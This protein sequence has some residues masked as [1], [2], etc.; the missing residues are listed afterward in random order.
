MATP[1]IGFDEASVEWA[2]RRIGVEGT[3]FKRLTFELSRELSDDFGEPP[4]GGGET[5]WK[6]AYVKA[7]VSRA[8]IVGA[9]RFKQPFGREA[10]TGETN[11]DFVYRSL[12]SR[13][14]TPGRDVGVM[15]EGRLLGR[16]IEYQ[17]GYFTRDGENARTSE[18]LGGEDAIV[19]RVVVSPFASA[20]S[21][22]WLAPLE[23]GVAV[24]NSSVDNRL[25]LR[26]RTVLGDGIFFDRVYVNG[27]RQRTGLEAAW[28]RGPASL[29]AE[30]ITAA[31][32]RH[33]MGF[34]GEDL[35]SVHAAS[36]YIA[37]TWALTGERKR[38]RLE[39]HHD[40]FRG[41]F[42]AIELAVRFENLKFDTIEYPGSQFG[43]PTESKLVGNAD[44]VTTLGVNW[45]LNDYLKIQ[46]NLITEGISDPARSPSS[47]EDG[48]FT[49]AVIRFQFRL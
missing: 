24:S 40:L 34:A 29:S 12:A 27:R 37:G 7:R 8:L 21:E 45:Y 11:L 14:L 32:E 39:P 30:Y 17:A 47:A 18:T 6:D 46:I 19:G 16:A 3:A 15:S 41:G 20:P 9:G 1:S 23:V 35:P 26:G 43:F 13:V 42:G 31:D 5:A 22:H 44:R 36:W 10:L 38:G 48:R 49:S 28:A 4:V 25:G 33:A 2:D